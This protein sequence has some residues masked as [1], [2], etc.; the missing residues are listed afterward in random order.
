MEPG[1]QLRYEYF[2]VN[3]FAN[4]GFIRGAGPARQH[5]LTP[6]VRLERQN[7][8]DTSINSRVTKSR[9]LYMS[10]QITFIKRCLKSCS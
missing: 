9:V 5:L 8:G 4:A 3:L 2:I 10:S 1:S 6:D 7:N